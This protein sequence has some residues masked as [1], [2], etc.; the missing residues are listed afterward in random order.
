LVAKIKE[1]KGMAFEK[2][3][4]EKKEEFQKKKEVV[5]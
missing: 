1:E 3:E 5:E 4:E 2:R